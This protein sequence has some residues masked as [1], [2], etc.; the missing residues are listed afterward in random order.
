M[1]ALYYFDFVWMPVVIAG[2]AACI[3]WSPAAAGW[4]LSGV[5]LF[6][7]IEYWVHRV[8]LHHIMWHSTHQR[9]HTHPAEYV[10]FPVWLIPLIY[11][12]FW[13]VLPLDIFVGF[14]VGGLWFAAWHHILHHWKLSGWVLS[15]ERWHNLHHRGLPVN[16]GIT[17]PLWDILF[18][19][20][21]SPSTAKW[22]SR[23]GGR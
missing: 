15:Y 22:G 8:V 12:A 4:A 7:L 10:S 2:I 21:K 9:H 19:T 16:Y 20:Y 6:T 1:K 3:D 17:H 13:L 11:F 5:A 14:L 18:L 23:Y